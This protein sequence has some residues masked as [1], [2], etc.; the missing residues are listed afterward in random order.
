VHFQVHIDVTD[1]KP[2]DIKV[3]AVN[4]RLSIS[5]KHEVR[6]ATS[7]SYK[8][9]SRTFDLPSNVEAKSLK[10]TITN[11]G[12]LLIDAPIQS[13][14]YNNAIEFNRKTETLPICATP[15]QQQNAVGTSSNI[16]TMSTTTSNQSCTT[17]QSLSITGKAGV[18]LLTVA[19][20]KKIHIEV[21]MTDEY[22]EEE[23]K[24]EFRNQTIYIYGR[25]E[26]KSATKSSYREF[27]KEFG[28]L[29]SVES[30]SFVKRVV[31]KTLIIEVDVI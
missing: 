23:I 25:H 26:E 2:E 5:A 27:N 1:Y 8:E 28:I 22:S 13:P 29:D 19:G 9:F 17:S 16:S 6:T 4:N 31:N 20:K 14:E 12:V 7:M 10:C 11:D 15:S 30:R 3:S 21:E 24:V 18:N